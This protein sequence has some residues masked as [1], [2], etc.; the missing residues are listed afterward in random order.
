M[1]F[2]F[3]FC[4][5]PLDDYAWLTPSHGHARLRRRSMLI[6]APPRHAVTCAVMPRHYHTMPRF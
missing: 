6:A 5:P 4:L 3:I 1:L 2:M